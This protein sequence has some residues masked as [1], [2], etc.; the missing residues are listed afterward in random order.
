MLVKTVKIDEMLEKTISSKKNLSM[1]T[2]DLNM[3]RY[4]SNISQA[5][6]NRHFLLDRIKKMKGNIIR[7]KKI[8]RKRALRNTTNVE[9]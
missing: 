2:I 8:E 4:W 5:Y 3:A 1:L 9:L 6:D 7:I